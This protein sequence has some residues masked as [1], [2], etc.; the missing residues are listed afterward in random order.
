M[1]KRILG[2]L[3][4]GITAAALLAGCG[5]KADKANSENTAAGS[6]DAGS[7]RTTFNVGFDAE[8]PPYGYMDESGAYTGFDLELA[9]A[10]CDIYGWE[11]IKTPINWD[12]KDMELNSGAIDCIWNGFTIN[13]RKDMYTWSVPYV[14]NSQ[15]IITSDRSGINALTDLA[16]KKVG[17]QAASTALEL[18]Q[19][20][21]KELA[22]TFAGGL[23]QEF[24]DYNNAFVELQAGSIDAIAM[25]IGVAQYQLKNRGDGFKILDEVLAA[26]QYGVGFKLGNT[27]LCDQINEGLLTLLDNG[28]FAELAQKYEL[29]DMICL[30]K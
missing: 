8:Y 20:D 27:E 7:D 5:A 18:L 1:K 23:P 26:E 17:V 2:F 25:D 11:L 30:K 15:V 22:D 19:G 28:T 14:D 12:S 9:Q 21:Q 3:M 6:N 4:A 29:Q 16:G 10:V 13:G 24:P